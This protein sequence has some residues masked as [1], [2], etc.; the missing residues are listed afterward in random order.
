[1]LRTL[2]VLKHDLA[3]LEV[4]LYVETVEKRRRIP[5]RIIELC[6]KWGTSHVFCN[7]EYEVD[8]L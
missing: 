6:E 5:G 2:E 3:A 7:M 1:M 8:E 4:P